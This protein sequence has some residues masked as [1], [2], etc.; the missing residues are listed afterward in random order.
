MYFFRYPVI[1]SIENHCSVKQQ[2][3]M[4][5]YIRSIF[6]GNSD[7]FTVVKFLL[8]HGGQTKHML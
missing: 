6:G 8:N 1:L 5:T 7:V 4:A 2:T 3:V